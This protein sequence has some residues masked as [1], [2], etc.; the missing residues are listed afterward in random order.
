MCEKESHHV[1][2]GEDTETFGKDN[3]I[4][5]KCTGYNT[6]TAQ[7]GFL[8][9]GHKYEIKFDVP[10][11]VCDF[12]LAEYLDVSCFSDIPNKNC[13]L[14]AA[15]VESEAVHIA[16]HLVA[17]KEKLLKEEIRI[18]EPT[19]QK[20]FTIHLLARVLGKNKGTPLL[21]NGVRCIGVESMDEDSEASD[22]QGF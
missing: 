13:Y 7:L 11:S 14:I 16:V 4:I 17:Y 19:R 18:T 21:R 5:V 6:V 3:E 8:K 20:G 10:C 1:H 15:V 2:F 22:W 9:L 12:R